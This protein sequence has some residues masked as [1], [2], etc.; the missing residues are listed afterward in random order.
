LP[1]CRYQLTK[2]HSDQLPSWE[3]I[4]NAVEIYA[5]NCDCQPLAL[6]QRDHLMKTYGERE[7]ELVCAL[8]AWTLRFA[9]ET[10]PLYAYIE[11]ATIYVD[12]A[13]A[14]AMY[15]ITQGQVELSTLQTLCIIGLLDFTG[16][17]WLSR[18]HTW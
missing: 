14:G 2:N 4:A 7:V 18:C 10:D 8:L 16:M 15:K 5:L 1:L 12:M 13:R 11:S 3:I 17:Y 9:E 6:F